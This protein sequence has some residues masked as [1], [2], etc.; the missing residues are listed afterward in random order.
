[1]K[2]RLICCLFGETAGIIARRMQKIADD[3]QCDRLISAVGVEN[4][5]SIAPAF[6]GVLIAPHIQYKIAEFI[7]ALYLPQEIAVI[8]SLPYATFDGEKILNFA[9]NTMPRALV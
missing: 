9:L 4:F 6:D 7:A 5:F 2:K 1:M 3:R 8:E